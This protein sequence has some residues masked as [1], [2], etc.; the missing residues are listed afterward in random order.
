[1]ATTPDR[2]HAVQRQEVAMERPLAA[3]RLSQPLHRAAQEI[4][5]GAV[6]GVQWGAAGGC[7]LIEARLTGA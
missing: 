5:Q 4:A 1:V 6:P 2:L 3:C 7:W